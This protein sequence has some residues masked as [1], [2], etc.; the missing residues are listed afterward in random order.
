V[1]PEGLGAVA[2]RR[3]RGGGQQPGGRNMERRKAEAKEETP[4]TT[5]AKGHRHPQCHTARHADTNPEAPSRGCQHPPGGA[6]TLP[7]PAAPSWGRHPLAL[8]LSACGGM[9]GPGRGGGS[10]SRSCTSARSWTRPGSKLT[11]TTPSGPP[12]RL[13]DP[14]CC[15]GWVCCGSGSSL[16][17]QGAGP[18]KGAWVAGR[19]DSG[20]LKGGA[21][22]L[23]GSRPA[24]RRRPEAAR[25]L[26]S[27]ASQTFSQPALQQART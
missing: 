4:M 21:G 24:G 6:G 19:R 3:E 26:T 20:P 12:C 23:A 14:G 18:E 11:A 16:R 17:G 13:T 7:G 8:T 9:P 27:R 15:A 1:A 25:P 2:R 10:S 22:R 5:A